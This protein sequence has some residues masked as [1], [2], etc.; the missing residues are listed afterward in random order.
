[1]NVFL[2]TSCLVSFFIPDAHHEK[3]KIVRDSIFRS[4]IRGL[5]SALSLAELCGVIRR[6]RSEAEA[7]EIKNAMEAIA[8]KELL[9]IIPI[10]NLDA[11]LA[12]DV[13]IKT[14]LKGAD[15]V[16]VNAAKQNETKLVTFDDEI[17]KK[18]K[19]YVEFYDG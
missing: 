10:S 17:K 1:M 7:T 8:E 3:A 18:A 5:V 9:T 14:G 13:A 2:D 15:A 19:G 6:N 11:S 16:I 4:E 12:S